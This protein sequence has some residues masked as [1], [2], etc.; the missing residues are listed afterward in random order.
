MSNVK[1]LPNR[2]SKVVL[3][4]AALKKIEE[5]VLILDAC[6]GED[7]QISDED[8]AALRKIADKLKLQCDDVF[9]IAKANR[10]FVEAPLSIEEMDKD[11]LFYEFCDKVRAALK[12]FLIK[13]D[14]EQNIAGAEYFNGCNVFESDVDAK[15]KRGNNAKAQ[16]IK[17]QLDAVDRKRGGNSSGNKNDPPPAK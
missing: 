13:L 7:T 16:N 2:I 9:T 15:I 1:L 8:Y 17:A 3:L 14:R 4:E 12:S 6:L 5:A 10:D 11:K